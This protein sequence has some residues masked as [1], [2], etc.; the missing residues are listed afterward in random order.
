[1]VSGL[2]ETVL[3]LAGGLTDTVL[4]LLEGLGL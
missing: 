2:L 4:S 1:M 3:G